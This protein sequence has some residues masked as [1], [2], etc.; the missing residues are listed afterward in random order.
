M[1]TQCQSRAQCSRPAKWGTYRWEPGDT[2]V[3]LRK[4]WRVFCGQHKPR[5]D[6]RVL[7]RN[8]KIA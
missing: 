7:A 3:N 4:P 2:G 8:V 5:L 6:K 1:T